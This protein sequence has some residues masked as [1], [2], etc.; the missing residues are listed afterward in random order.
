MIFIVCF[1][2]GFFGSSRNLFLFV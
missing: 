1:F 2:P